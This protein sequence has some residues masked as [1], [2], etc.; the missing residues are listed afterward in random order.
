MKNLFSIIF[1]LLFSVVYTQELKSFQFYNQK[2]KR[3][4][5]GRVVK[6][7][8]QYDVILFG[9]HHNN[10]MNHWLQSRLMKALYEFK[11]QHLIVGAEMF[12]RDQQDEINNYL[13]HKL[14]L[15]S[16]K[17][18]VKLWSNYPTDYHPFMEFAKEHQ[19]SFIATN[20][21][22]RYASIVAKKGLDEL[23]H[24]TEED[25]KWM[26]QIPLII[27]YQAPGYPEMLQMIGDHNHMQAKQFVAA[28][29][30]KDATM[31]ETIIKNLKKNSLLLHFNGDYHS[32]Q[33]G[34]I[35]WYLKYFRPA[36]KVA[37]IQILESNGNDLKLEIPTEEHFILTDF[38]LVLPADT[39]KTF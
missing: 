19:L 27:D 3:V 34:G 25:K 10:S 14:D 15:K 1:I 32:K 31:A 26:V 36:L 35:Y 8:G 6:E 18:K 17:E 11:K 20:I 22:R 33:Y 7:L 37:V 24:L 13:N 5:F 16:F 21:P 2:G 38:T 28:Q 4:D 30:I 9:E 12:E 23:N 39:N 29:A